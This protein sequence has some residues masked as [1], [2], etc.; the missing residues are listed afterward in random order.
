M[1][2]EA[3][4]SDARAKWEAIASGWELADEFS[5]AVEPVSATMIASVDP[6][7]GQTI[8]E[9]AAGRGDT[10]LLA[11]EAIRP[12]GKLII[13]DGAQEMVKGA[14]R[15]ARAQG[16]DDAEFKAMELE[17]LDADAASIDAILCRFGYMHAV[18]PEA[19]L[20]EARRVLKPGGRIAIAVWDLPERN[21]LLN[22]PR[23]ALGAITD[24]P[25]AFALA[26]HGQVQELLA[27]AGFEDRE[28]EP[29]EIF[30]R[31]D[32]L[33]SMWDIVM[34]I[35]STMV[36]L[37]KA[38][39]PAEHV[40]LRDAVDAGWGDYVGAGGSVAVPGRALVASASA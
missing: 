35:S 13:T 21:P 28:V 7:P 18:D 1:D 5:R 17:W 37:V 36:P 11:A 32:S 39:S 4:R 38:L 24:G 20:R 31:A 25:G 34:G 2:P 30:F 27:V 9:V 14:E 40:A 26:D 16:V 19:A 33:D 6:K 29:V 3:H 15:H 10:G 23:V 8:L 22:V 12:D